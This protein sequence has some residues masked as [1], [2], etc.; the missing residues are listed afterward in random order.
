MKLYKEKGNKIHFKGNHELSYVFWINHFKTDYAVHFDIF[1][2]QFE[3]YMGKID[4]FNIFINESSKSKI[5]RILD[6]DGKFYVTSANSNDL[7]VCLSDPKFLFEIAEE[8]SLKKKPISFKS[9]NTLKLL[10]RRFN[11]N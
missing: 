9:C 1:W 4:Y 7:F 6:P 10:F 5:K 2:N 8:V 11:P 3:K